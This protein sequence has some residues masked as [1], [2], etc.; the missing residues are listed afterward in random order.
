MEMLDWNGGLTRRQWLGGAAAAGAVAALPAWA[1][2]PEAWPNVTGLI[3][4]YVDSRKVANMV[5]ALGFG[6]DEPTVIASGL[7]S[8]TAP[9][10][11]DA[12]SLYRI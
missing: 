4:R 5:V 1:Q 3:S 11:S 9:R 12:D 6:H 2:S 7:D 10:R 8:F